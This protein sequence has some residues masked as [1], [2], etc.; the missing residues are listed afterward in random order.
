MPPSAEDGEIGL[1]V[2][3][4][5]E[6]LLARFAQ[7]YQLLSRPQAFGNIFQ[8][9]VEPLGRRAPVLLGAEAVDVAGFVDEERFRFGRRKADL[10]QEA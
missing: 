3:Q 8:E 10:G 4:R 5:G 9:L 6:N 1:G 2:G 7:T